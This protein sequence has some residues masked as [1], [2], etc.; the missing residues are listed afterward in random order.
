MY[1][2]YSE[3]VLNNLNIYNGACLKLKIGKKPFPGWKRQ[4]PASEP[5]PCSDLWFGISLMISYSSGK[6]HY[7][8]NIGSLF[9]RTSIK[10]EILGQVVNR[11]G[12]C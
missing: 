3:Y 8:K 2:E 12:L 6:T 4:V 9:G 1:S 10:T 11:V 7:S 5:K